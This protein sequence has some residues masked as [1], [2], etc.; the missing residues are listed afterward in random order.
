MLPTRTLQIVFAH[1][2]CC[3]ITFLL[4]KRAVGIFF[5]PRTNVLLAKIVDGQLE[6]QINAFYQYGV[7]H[8]AVINIHGESVTKE[9][10]DVALYALKTAFKTVSGFDSE[11]AIYT[12]LGATINNASMVQVLLDQMKRVFV[13][14]VFVSITHV[15]HED[16]ALKDC[17]IVPPTWL[18]VPNGE[19]SYGLSLVCEAKSTCQG[20]TFG[21]AAYDI[22]YD[23]Q[24]HHPQCPEFGFLGPLGRVALLKNMNT[25]LTSLSSAAAF[26]KEECLRVEVTT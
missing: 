5:S 24:P 7:R 21:V 26:K 2:S 16:R 11:E 25:Y 19:V 18:S 22:E 8:T 15:S 20:V 13:P 9:G 17:R 1:S 4:N 3:A 23:N 14:S 10:L 6:N 12:V